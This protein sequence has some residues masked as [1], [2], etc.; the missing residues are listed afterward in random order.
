MSLTGTYEFDSIDA[1]ELLA[2]PEAPEIIAALLEL[3]RAKCQSEERQ[4]ETIQSLLDRLYGRKSEKSK[5]HPD[6]K[7]LLPE[8]LEESIN[9]ASGEME[10]GLP[11]SE[12]FDDKV[13]GSTDTPKPKR[14]GGHGRSKL[15]GHLERRVVERL[16]MD[17]PGCET[18][19][20]PASD[21]SR[22]A[23][24]A[25]ELHPG[26]GDCRCDGGCDSWPV[27]LLVRR[28]GAEDCS[29]GT[30]VAS[31]RSRHAGR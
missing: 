30:S 4:R 29:P 15:P 31:D 26:Q 23:I 17:A 16:D 3:Y 27:A 12:S 21:P 1:K 28:R 20:A 13:N 2:S 7:L 25:A 24:R 9:E 10:I 8:L 19:D 22:R 18:C 11:E 14:K 5:Y 6:Q